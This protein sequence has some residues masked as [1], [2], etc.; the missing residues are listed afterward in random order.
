MPTYRVRFRDDKED[1]VIKAGNMGESGPS[2][3]FYDAA[4]NIVAQVPRDAVLSVVDE[5]A[6]GVGM[7]G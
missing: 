5:K 3:V 6:D 2:Y 1:Q 7:G 4:G